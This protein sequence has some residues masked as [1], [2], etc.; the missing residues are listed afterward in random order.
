MARASTVDGMTTALIVIDV[1]Q[2]FYD[3]AQPPRNNPDFEANLTT[4]LDAWA[5]PIVLVRHDSAKPESPLRPGQPG[6]DFLPVL[7]GVRSELMFTKQVNSA[8][9]G[10]VDL[11][12]WLRERGIHDLVLA[13]IQTNWC[14]ETTARVGGNLGY[15]VTVAI[16]ATFTFDAQG[17]DG[18]TLTADQ[19]AAATAVNLHAGGFARIARTKELV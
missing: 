5:G 13:G 9:H 18:E 2:G 14:V 6:N 17:P 15:D 1:Q 19:L 10:S 7:D 4:L 8:F 3:P 16:D 11:H 12:R